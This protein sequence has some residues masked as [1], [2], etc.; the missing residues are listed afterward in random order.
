[1]SKIKT[2]GLH[3]YGKVQSLRGIGGERVKIL[4]SFLAFR[5]QELISHNKNADLLTLSITHV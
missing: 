1:M 5:V 2:A 3:Q 4:A